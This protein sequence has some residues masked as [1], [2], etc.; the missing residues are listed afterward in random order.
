MTGN[1]SEDLAELPMPA[2]ACLVMKIPGFGGYR[3][4]AIG[5]PHAASRPT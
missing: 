2:G 3:I 4:N 5:V 1:N